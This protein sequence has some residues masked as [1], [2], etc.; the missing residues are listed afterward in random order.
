VLHT[1]IIDGKY[2]F[3]TQSDH[4]YLAKSPMDMFPD[5]LIPNDL[6]EVRKAIIEYYGE[7]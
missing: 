1:Q 7:E 3:Q 2:L 5:K 6:A 4:E